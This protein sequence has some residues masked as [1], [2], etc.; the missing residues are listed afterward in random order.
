MPFGIGRSL[1]KA[2]RHPKKIFTNPSEFLPAGTLLGKLLGKGGKAVRGPPKEGEPGS[3]GF[4]ERYYAGPGDQKD[5]GSY[6]HREPGTTG[7]PP[8]AMGGKGSRRGTTQ[9]SSQQGPDFNSGGNPF[10]QIAQN[11]GVEGGSPPPAMGGKGGQSG[12]S[13][14]VASNPLLASATA[15]PRSTAP[16]YSVGNNQSRQT[17]ALRRP[18]PIGRVRRGALPNMNAK[19]A[20]M[21]GTGGGNG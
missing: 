1:K 15:R 18:S 7:S 3:A 2:V 10:A 16:N 12:N 4:D 17:A 9:S 21:G 11:M 6:L 14:F 8:P 19:T 20:P 13:G 5:F